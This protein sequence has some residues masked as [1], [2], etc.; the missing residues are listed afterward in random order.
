M[1]DGAAGWVLYGSLDL[2]ICLLTIGYWLLAIGYWLLAIG[3]WL[4]D[5]GR[6]PLARHGRD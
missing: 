2:L 6:L 1:S 5:G 3:Y 4:L